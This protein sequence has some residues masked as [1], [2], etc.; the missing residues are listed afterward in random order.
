MNQGRFSYLRALPWLVLGL[1]LLATYG[2]WKLFDTSI[3]NSADR[4]F[5]QEVRATEHA[6]RD[7]LHAYETILRGTVGMF[8]A[9]EDVTR[10]EFKTFIDILQLQRDYPGI[11]GIGYSPVISA[12]DLVAHEAD[13]RAEGFSDYSVSPP[14]MRD[15]YSPIVYIEPFNERNQRAFGFDM[16][17]EPIRREALERARDNGNTAISGKLTL[18]QEIGAEAQ[19]G[20]VMFMP[21]YR[22]ARDPVDPARRRAELTGYVH[23]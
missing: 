19:P 5:E 12:A 3:T 8:Y 23:A 7:R 22:G 6:I 9:S 11:Q 20:F 21:I 2:A 10:A 13:I 1:G 4:R 17:T 18:V 14:D 16:N 15:A